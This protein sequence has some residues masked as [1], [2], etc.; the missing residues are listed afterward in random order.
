MSD[1]EQ[2]EIIYNKCIPPDAQKRMEADKI[3]KGHNEI[4]TKEL[5]D[6]NL[7]DLRHFKYADLS[8]LNDKELEFLQE[9]LIFYF[10]YHD[11]TQLNKKVLRNGIYGACGAYSFHFYNLDLAADITA[12]ARNM[13]RIVKKL[14]NDVFNGKTKIPQDVLNELGITKINYPESEK[15]YIVYG[16]TDSNYIDVGSFIESIEFVNDSEYIED[17]VKFILEFDK[18]FLDKHIQD[19]INNYISKRNGKSVIVY[20]NEKICS[21]AIFPNKKKH[22]AMMVV[23]SDGKYLSKPKI[24]KVGYD[25]NVI[26][27]VSRGFMTRNFEFLLQPREITKREYRKYMNEIKAEFSS[28]ELTAK[29]RM[30]AIKKYNEYVVND[31][32]GLKFKPRASKAIKGAAA[33][34]YYVRKNGLAGKVDLLGHTDRVSYYEAKSSFHGGVFS[35]DASKPIPKFA[36]EIDDNAAFQDMVINPIANILEVSGFQKHSKHGTQRQSIQDL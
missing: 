25:K 32:T 12:E 17:G 31:R 14:V 5:D 21:S 19:Y 23:W 22:Y 16:D 13:I 24:V 7:L 30:T 28:K 2:L 9:K 3:L 10:G 1:K 36:P 34:N 20:E 6:L 15:N 27:K 8:K 33:F 35:F 18:L 11:T 29:C 4:I 26:P